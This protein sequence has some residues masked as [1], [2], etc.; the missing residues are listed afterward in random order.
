MRKTWKPWD[1]LYLYF[2][3]VSE[4]ERHVGAQTKGT[5]PASCRRIPPRFQARCWR[6]E[7]RPSRKTISLHVVAWIRRF[8]LVEH[9]V[10]LPTI[11]RRINSITE[12][13]S[14]VVTPNITRAT[15]ERRCILS[16]ADLSITY[17]DIQMAVNS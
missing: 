10:M 1:I 11:P 14:R 8:S 2:T 3:Y 9:I 13:H 6:E 4:L 15:N 16:F 12:I 7:R 17:T 5:N